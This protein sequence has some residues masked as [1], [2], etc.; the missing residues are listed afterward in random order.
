MLTLKVLNFWKFASYCSLKPL[1]SGMGEVVPARTSPTLHPPIPSHCAS[2]VA[3][4]T[5]RVLTFTFLCDGYACLSHLNSN[6]HLVSEWG[7][8]CSCMFPVPRG[9]ISWVV[10]M[11]SS[12]LY[13]MLHVVW[14]R[15]HYP[16]ILYWVPESDG[17][18]NGFEGLYRYW[19]CA[20]K[21]YPPANHH[22]IHL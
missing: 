12:S 16:I 19:H 7:N 18:I 9:L 22:A 8:T 14:L 21:N 2:I 13:T 6:I 4:S 17:T 1:W 20:K 11:L 15:L 3:T 5:L 10:V